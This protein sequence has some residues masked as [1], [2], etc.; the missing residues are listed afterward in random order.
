[1]HKQTYIWIKELRRKKE[2]PFDD[3]M[4][5]TKNMKWASPYATVFPRETT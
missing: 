4:T 5:G 1:M 2:E 3:R